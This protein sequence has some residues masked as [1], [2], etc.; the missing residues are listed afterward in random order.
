MNLHID[1][2]HGFDSKNKIRVGTTTMLKPIC[3][4]P[5]ASRMQKTIVENWKTS[6]MNEQRIL[7]QNLIQIDTLI[8][9]IAPRTLT[10]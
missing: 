3:E 9:E 6:C 7:N 5:A 10:F 8:D 2:E 1:Y 4:K